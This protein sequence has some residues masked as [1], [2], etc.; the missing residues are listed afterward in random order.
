MAEDD[1]IYV[2]DLIDGMNEELDFN[3]R[4]IHFSLEY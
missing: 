2:T 1:K 3:D 4:V